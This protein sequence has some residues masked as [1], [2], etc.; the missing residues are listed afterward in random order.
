MRLAMFAVVV[1]LITSVT[2]LAQTD[3]K[4]LLVGKWEAKEKIGEAELKINLEFTKDAL[5]VSFD[6]FKVEGKYKWADKDTLE[7]TI[8]G[9]DGKDMT[10]KTKVVVT[11]DTLSLTGKDGKETKFTRAKD[12]P[13]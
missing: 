7:V 6:T 9:M 10:E 2:T 3:A 5:K 11:K 1:T 4:E 13:K 8:T 12:A